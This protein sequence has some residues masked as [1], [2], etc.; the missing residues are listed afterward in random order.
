MATPVM[1]SSAV[2]SIKPPSAQ[3][4]ANGFT[5]SP[6]PKSKLLGGSESE[7]DDQGSLFGGRLDASDRWLT[8]NESKRQK[9]LK[10]K[11][12]EISP[13]MANFKKQDKKKTP[14]HRK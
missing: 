13:D 3:S 14:K 1:S 4:Q 2:S 12:L 8:M 6:R 7:S 9:R 11:Q 5:F 10:R